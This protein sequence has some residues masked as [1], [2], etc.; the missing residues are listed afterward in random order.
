MQRLEV[1]GAVRHMYGSL[2]VKRLM[3][4]EFSVMLFEGTSISSLMTICPVTAELFH[5]DG[6]TDRHNEASRREDEINTL[7]LKHR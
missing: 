5:P 3:K 1:S 6:Q 4:L 2:G 7:P